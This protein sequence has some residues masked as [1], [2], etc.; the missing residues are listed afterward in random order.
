MSWNYLVHPRLLKLYEEYHDKGFEIL[1]FTGDKQPETL[2]QDSEVASLFYP[3]GPLYI[4]IK[5]EIALL[6]MI[7]T[8]TEFLS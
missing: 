2:S 8:S 3:P 7:I 1:G 4:Q 5:R 6:P